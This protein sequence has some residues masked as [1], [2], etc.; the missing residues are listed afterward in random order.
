VAAR[1][2]RKQG[3]KILMKNYR[4]RFGE[5]DIVC[6][7]KDV[8]VFVE[9]KARQADGLQRPGQAITPKKQ[10]RLLLTGQAYLKE[11]KKEV[12]HRHDVVEVYLDGDEVLECKHFTNIMG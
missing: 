10:R 4:S 3:M 12:P 1:F 6:R 7:Q 9:V 11:L 2:L 8:L 5:I